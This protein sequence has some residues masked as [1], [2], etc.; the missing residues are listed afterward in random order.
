MKS[1]GACL[2]LPNGNIIHWRTHARRE[3]EWEPGGG[4]GRTWTSDCGRPYSHI[5]ETELDHLVYAD[6]D[7][8]SKVT[9]LCCLAVA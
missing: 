6:S 4:G 5:A 2:R 7:D 3:V 9:C 8:F 1:I